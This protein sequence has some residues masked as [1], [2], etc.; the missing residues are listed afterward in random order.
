M[1]LKMEQG[2]GE[3]GTGGQWGRKKGRDREEGKLRG[4]MRGKEGAEKNTI[5][6]ELSIK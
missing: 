6:I 1:F 5:Y 4:R 2:Q 3:K